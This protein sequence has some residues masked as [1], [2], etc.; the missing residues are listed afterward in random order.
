MDPVFVG[1]HD[2]IERQTLAPKASVHGDFA[3]PALSREDDDASEAAESLP[4]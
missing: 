1:L 3:H 4:G 2:F